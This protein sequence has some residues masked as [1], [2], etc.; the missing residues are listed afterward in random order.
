[1]T[2]KSAELDSWKNNQVYV[3]K[4]DIGQ[5][6]ISTRWICNL[7]ETPEGIIPKARL[8]A[9]GFEEFETRSL[10]K[11]S[12]TCATESL[13]LVLA[14]LA[15]KRWKPHS[16]DIKTAFIQGSEL[17]R[18]IFIRRPAEAKVKGIV[19]QLQKCVYGLADASLYWYN[20]VRE[21]MLQSG[22]K[23]SLADPAVF[24]WKN[25]QGTVRG[26]LSCQSWSNPVDC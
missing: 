1:M 16:T 6:C 18:D 2:A 14:V 23:I 3:E 5:K 7:K 19:W 10:P 11:D 12:P 8:V 26:I 20:K 17:D 4:Y 13:R 21:V 24:Y 25:Y 9:R 22:A 15:A